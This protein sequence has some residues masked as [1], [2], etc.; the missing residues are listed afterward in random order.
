MLKQNF[1]SHS[2]NYKTETIEPM[3]KIFLFVAI[4]SIIAA[5]GTPDKNAELQKLKQE[6][7]TL[8]AKIQALEAEIGSTD[9][10]N[11]NKNV[12][13]TE[14][15]PTTFIHYIDVQGSI[16]AQQSVEIQPQMP[17]LVARVLVT[18]GQT[19][20]A[21]QLLAELDNSIA[22]ASLTALQPQY[23]L[24]LELYNRQKRLWEQK[25][26]AEV[27]YLQAKTQKESLEKNMNTIREQIE[28]SQ[29]KSPISGVV[30]VVNLKVGQYAAPSPIAAIRVVNLG[31]LKVKSTLA[32][33]Y[34]NQV[35]KG[36]E[37]KI[38]FPDLGT[39][40]TSSVTHVAKTIDPLTRTFVVESAITGDLTNYRPNMVGV[41]KI[42]DY[43][44]DN[45]FIVPLN[46]IQ[47]SES[48][49]YVYIAVN[50]GGKTIA[51]KKEVQVG[52]TYNGTAEIIG[53]LAQ[54]DKLITAGQFDMVDGM[55]INIKK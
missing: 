16:D 49:Q 8:G 15:Q 37:T 35:K 29:I 7:A 6:Y 11:N 30:D 21:G 34:I 54:G 32:E 53:G 51:R 55:A 52:K 38:N 25:I 31:S 26:G 36:N 14:L 17:G 2:T 1:K 39:E 5:C 28:L 43:K 44:N 46:N 18:E 13:V 24:A 12:Q 47:N 50:E 9:S 10:T 19:V 45:A 3:K 27:N 40:I 41:I 22:N 23:D 42:V 4:A 33:S 48:A 20:Q